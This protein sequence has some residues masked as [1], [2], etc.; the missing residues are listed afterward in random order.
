MRC[1]AAGLI[2]GR[3]IWQRPWEDALRLTR[4]IREIMLEYAGK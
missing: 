4:Q 3:N 1:G 2:F